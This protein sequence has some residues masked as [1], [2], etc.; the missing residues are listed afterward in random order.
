MSSILDGGGLT[1]QVREVWL[2]DALYAGTETFLGWQSDQRGRLLILHTDSGGT[3]AETGRAMEQLREHGL[4]YRNTADGVVTAAELRA[5][6]VVFVHTDLAHHEV[7]AKGG[8]FKQ[9]L[10]T[11]SLKGK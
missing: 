10:E 4:D 5:H 11:S 1:T 6:R 7:V 9:F 8:L 2:F 3:A